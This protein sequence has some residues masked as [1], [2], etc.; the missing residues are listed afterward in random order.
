MAPRVAS[1][2]FSD[3]AHRAWASVGPMVPLAS[4]SSATGDSRV[5]MSTRRATHLSLRLSRRAMALGLRPSSFINEQTTLASSSAVRVRG[6]ELA[7]SSKRLCSTVEFGGSMTTGMWQCPCS[8]QRARRLKPSMT[9][10]A[11][12]SVGT[13]RMGSCAVQSGSCCGAPGRKGA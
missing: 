7:R 11:P 9:S 10:Y 4:L 6:G 13:M 3:K 2:S 12:S 8:R 1:C 5:P